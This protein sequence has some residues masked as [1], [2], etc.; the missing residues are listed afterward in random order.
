MALI[1][2]LLERLRVAGGDTTDIEVKSSAG[3]LSP[4]VTST[5]SALANLPGGGWLV[6]G[7][8]ES[9]GFRP[10]DLPDL[11]GLKQ[12]VAGKA[13]S[14]SPP[15]T[16]TFED[17][18]VEGKSVVV[19]KV[20]ECAPSAKPCRVT[21]SGQAWLRS[22]DG[23]YTM[24]QLEE[25]AFLAQRQHPHFDRLPVEG[26]QFSDLDPELVEVWAAT[27]STLD[28]DGLGRFEGRE[29]LFHGGV[30][31][32]GDVPTKAGLLALGV[33]PQRFFPR[34]VLNLAVTPGPGDTSGVRARRPAT[35]S[36]PIPRMLDAALAWAEREFD[37][38]IVEGAG[39]TVQDAWAYPLEAF[40]E[41]IGNA[42]VHRDLDAWSEGQAVEVRL[43]PDRLVV[44][45][46]GGLYG[47][48]VDR[49]GRVGTTSARNSLLIEVCRY[50]RSS[51]GARVVET[52]AS[53]IP[54]VL[55]SMS[56]AGQDLPVFQD[57]G[58]QFTAVLRARVEAPAP[59]PRRRDDL[60]ELEA[61]SVQLTR[62]QY[63]VLEALTVGEAVDVVELERRTGMKAPNIRK[64]LRHLERLGLTSHQGGRGK[65]TTYERIT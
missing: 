2:D 59:L 52:L 14:C 40:R 25:Q 11:Q 47:I 55:S 33:H 12:G 8:D 3:G 27:A 17:A 18:E 20:A 57:S 45:N 46:P 9:A 26:A 63:A 24:S 1:D 29:L 53:G 5:L 13:R 43:L 30:V 62:S 60:V 16:V 22:W 35:L 7:L 34:Y 32:D 4:S 10:V 42:L 6:L 58:L 41:L 36:G 31:V 50:A 54:K 23:D 19:A 21:S 65:P 44:T 28:P 48:T 15:V 38:G 56:A 51:S 49:L 39:G 37:R 64:Q 61:S